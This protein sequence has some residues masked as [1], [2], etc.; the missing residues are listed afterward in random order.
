[1]PITMDSERI[2]WLRRPAR[3]AVSEGPWSP[4]CDLRVVDDAWASMLERNARLVDGPCW[5]VTSVQRDGHGGATI[6]V[7]QTTYRMGA[8]RAVGVASGFRGLG[9]KA[10]AHLNGLCLVGRRAANCATYPG[11]WEFAPGGSAEPGEDPSIGIVRELMEECAVAAAAPARQRALLFDAV[12]GNWEIVH[13]IELAGQ[14]DAP[15]NWEYTELRMIDLSSMP[16]PI[17]PC[18]RGMHEIAC[19]VIERPRGSV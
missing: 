2:I 4:Q 11:A 9:V 12:A 5:H 16:S 14:P 10:I 15:P 8:V 19:R 6:H 18:T 13:A 1:M 17:S 7:V 3:M